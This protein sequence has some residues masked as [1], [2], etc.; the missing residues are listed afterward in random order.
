MTQQQVTAIVLAAGQGT[1]MKSDLHKVLHPIGGKPM[2]H[3]VL[4]AA[5]ALNPAKTI[6]VVGA[7]A[8]QLKAAVP[9]ADFAMQ[10]EQLGT[11][12]A[13]QMA[14]PALDGFD[15]DL[16]VLYG[17]IPLLPADVLEDMLTVRR[18]N[19]GIGLVV[20]GFEAADPGAYGRLVLD[21]D[22]SLERIVEYKDATAAE[23]AI[24]LCNS[25]MMLIDGAQAKVWLNRL[26]NNNAAGEYY[27]TDLVAIARADGATVAV[28]STSE[29]NVAGVNSRAD[30][31]AAE[32]IFQNKKRIAFMAAGVTLQ[33]PETVFFSHDTQIG[34]DVIIEPNVV[35]GPGAVVEDGV[36]LKA[37]SH[38]EGAHVREE[39][40]VGPFTRLRP[41]A[42]I[43][44]GAKIGNFVEIK[45]SKLEAG[46]KVSHLTYLGDAAIGANANIGAGTI[47]C[48]YD[49]FLKYQTTIGEG[50]FIGSNS[51]LVAPVS[52]GD[53]AIVG[54][55]SVVTKDVPVD[56]L[57]VSRARQRDID[58][59]AAK[60]R[61]EKQAEKAA[62]VAAHPPAET[63]D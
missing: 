53:G 35:F 25:G 34:R 44:E 59:Y 4:D 58:G 30:L 19:T 7:K 24:T 63:K 3:H 26:E 29:T 27:L 50:A 40:S 21:Q 2:V 5:N 49:G 38:I 10:S 61:T 51:S 18:Q 33:A 13:V 6:L 20:L 17:D 60:F 32:A 9:T 22:G 46:V 62:K 11:G 39:A 55:G 41:A 23:R 45:K 47:T 57:A 56:A 15:G 48:N 28:T 12:H 36:T 1:R 54:A 14:I 52:V 16:L 42:D 37:F 31:A 43:G 8:E